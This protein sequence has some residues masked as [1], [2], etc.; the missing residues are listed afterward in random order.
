M[1]DGN[2][3]FLLNYIDHCVKLLWSIPL[4]SMNAICLHMHFY[5]F[6]H[7]LVHPIFYNVMMGMNSHNMQWIIL[8]GNCI[9]MTTLLAHP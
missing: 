1:H 6:F 7:S 5:R 4:V 3:K 8:V 2:V 9:W